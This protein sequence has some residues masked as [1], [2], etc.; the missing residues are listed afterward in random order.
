MSMLKKIKDN[1][2]KRQKEQDNNKWRITTDEGTSLA[3]R[4]RK[5][6]YKRKQRT[7]N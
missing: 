2:D 4:I 3:S 1:A 6:E 5:E 7:T